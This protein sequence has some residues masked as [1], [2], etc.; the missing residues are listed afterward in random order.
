[1]IWLA[2]VIGIATIIYLYLKNINNYWITKSVKQGKPWL[3]FGDI[4]SLILKKESFPDMME[5]IYNEC[6]GTR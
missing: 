1:M 2:F 3:L 4:W 6:P 5:R